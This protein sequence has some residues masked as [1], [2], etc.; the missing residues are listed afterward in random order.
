MMTTTAALRIIMKRS[1]ILALGVG[2]RDI[3]TSVSA[4][5]HL[6]IVKSEVIEYN[7]Y[8]H[9]VDA[10]YPHSDAAATAARRQ[11]WRGGSVACWDTA[12]SRCLV[13]GLIH[14]STYSTPP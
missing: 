14:R 4:W 1:D 2:H 6:S 7:R 8:Q 5:T 13:A 9:T 11:G 10:C 3:T 12:A